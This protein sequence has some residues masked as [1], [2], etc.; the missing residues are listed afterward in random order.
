MY[1]FISKPYTLV[2]ALTS[3]AE[4]R[5]TASPSWPPWLAPTLPFILHLTNVPKIQFSP[6]FSGLGSIQWRVLLK[7]A[8]LPPSPST[9]GCGTIISPTSFPSSPSQIPTL[10]TNRPLHLSEQADSLPPPSLFFVSFATPHNLWV[11]SSP[12]RDQTQVPGNGSL[13]S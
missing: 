4:L 8:D 5:V 13:K 10:P 2:Q 9:Q 3:H 12:M 11:L 7:D 1:P 6:S